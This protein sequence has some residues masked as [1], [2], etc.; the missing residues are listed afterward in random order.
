VG[1]LGFELPNATVKM[2][3]RRFAP[4]S[5]YFELERFNFVELSDDFSLDSVGIV[6][7]RLEVVEAPIPGTERTI[8][9][10]FYDD[11]EDEVVDYSW[12]ATAYERKT[13]YIFSIGVLE[14]IVF[15]IPGLDGV[16]LAVAPTGTEHIGVTFSIDENGAYEISTGINL[17]LRFDKGL[18]K[19]MLRGV[20]DEGKVYFEEETSVDHT[21]IEL[22]G[23]QVSY[24]ADGIHLAAGMSFDVNRPVMIGDSGVILEQLEDVSL[25]F[26][27]DGE[28]P[29]GVPDDWLGVFIGQATARFGANSD[30]GS[31]RLTFDFENCRIGS[32]GFS[33]RAS[34]LFSEEE[35]PQADILGFKVVIE[36]IGLTF[37][38]NRLADSLVRGT[39]GIPFFDDPD[40]PSDPVQFTAQISN[41]GSFKVAL[42]AKDNAENLAEVRIG[43]ALTLGVRKLLVEKSEDDSEAFMLLT[44]R[45]I[46][47]P[48]AEDALALDIE[49]LKIYPDGRVDL[50][51][52]WFDVKEKL[53]YNKSGFLIGI[54]KIGIGLDADEKNWVGFSGSLRLTEDLPSG[55]SVEGLRYSWWKDETGTRQSRFT[56]AG[57]ALDFDVPDLFRFST[58]LGFFERGEPV[59]LD[60]PG[61]DTTYISGLLGEL[62]FQLIPFR[63]SAT[64]S[65]LVARHYVDD[66]EDLTEYYLWLVYLD[67]DLPTGIL[68]ANTGLSIY[69]F[70]GLITQNMRPNKP[71]EAEWYRDW[72]RQDP[73]GATALSKWGSFDGALGVGIGA[74]F[75]TSVD[76]G[77]AFSARVLLAASFPGPILLLA[78][79]ANILEDRSAL[80]DPGADPLFRFLVVFDALES[81]LLFCLEVIYIKENILEIGGIAEVFV[82]FD[83]PGLW[84]IYVGEEPPDR[85][86]R[87]DILEIFEANAYFML[88]NR[89]VAFGFYIGYSLDKRFGPL[90]LKIAAYLEAHALISW[91]P[92]LYAGGLTLYG[93]V[94]LSAF[95]IELGLAVQAMVEAAGPKPWLIAAEFR[96]KLSLPWPL[97][98]P[99][100]TV[101]LRWEE[102]IPPAFPEPI[103]NI[104]FDSHSDLL[105]GTDTFA[106]YHSQAEA[107]ANAP[108]PMDGVLSIIF[109]QIVENEWAT[110][111][112][113]P[114]S[115][116]IIGQDD[117]E[118]QFTYSITDLQLTA[119]GGD[120]PT[121]VACWAPQEFPDEPPAED[122]PQKA[123]LQINTSDVFRVDRMVEMAEWTEWDI[124]RFGAYFCPSP[125]PAPIHCWSPGDDLAGAFI[126]GEYVAEGF[127]VRVDGVASAG[128][129]DYGPD[130]LGTFEALSGLFGTQRGWLS[131][132]NVRIELLFD[133]GVAWVEVIG[134]FRGQL[135]LEIYAGSDLLYRDVLNSVPLRRFEL[136]SDVLIV[137]QHDPI[138]RVVLQG[139]EIHLTSVCYKNH[140]DEVTAE[141]AIRQRRFVR[142]LIE[143]WEADDP[144]FEPH[145]TYQLSFTL[146]GQRRAIGS[147]ADP[148]ERPWEAIYFFRTG[149]PPSDLAAY[150]K[151]SIPGDGE[152]RFFRSYHVEV[153]FIS[154]HVAL[155]YHKVDAPLYLMLTA[156]SGAPLHERD[157]TPI[158]DAA[159]NP[160]RIPYYPATGRT[161]RL[162]ESQQRLVDLAFCGTPPPVEDRP[163]PTLR[164]TPG[165]YLL[166]PET[167]YVGYLGSDAHPDTKLYELS[168]TTSRFEDFRSMI[169]SRID[170]FSHHLSHLTDF[171][172]EPRPPLHL[173]AEDKT[174]ITEIHTQYGWLAE[175]GEDVLQHPLPDRDAEWFAHKELR[176]LLDIGPYLPTLGTEMYELRDETT[177][178]GFLIQFA[179]PVDW[180]RTLLT[181]TLTRTEHES[182]VEVDYTDSNFSLVRSRDG[183]AAFIKFRPATKTVTDSTGL[184]HYLD[185]GRFDRFRDVEQPIIV[186]PRNPLPLREP[187]PEQP[188][189][190][191]EILPIIPSIFL[192]IIGTSSPR[193]ERGLLSTLVS[194]IPA[195]ARL[196][197]AWGALVVERILSP[198]V[199]RAR[200]VE[201]DDLHLRLRLNLNFRYT[202][203]FSRHPT[204]ASAWVA[205]QA[206]HPELPILV[207]QG[208]A[209]PAETAVVIAEFD[210][211]GEMS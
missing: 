44:A 197:A 59:P 97:P 69:G 57:A 210:H 4:L 127:V 31:E 143:Q 83:D 67:V 138:T 120:A 38:S 169:E 185:H 205:F 133:Q 126:T 46:L 80:A 102:P 15:G 35:L 75:G 33:G 132:G 9:E 110:A 6:D 129:L 173:S 186:R 152:V 20:T 23:V 168:F 125:D 49:D 56:L 73:I 58:R 198:A 24:D 107:E 39:L 92:Q 211:L 116:I 134:A 148:D 160:L 207:T 114:S 60:A 7:S 157:G 200:Q 123:I 54:T 174:R 12:T 8:E 177:H 150:V 199:D 65:F 25:Y 182:D 104:Q 151:R 190:D 55:A 101:R 70:A 130:Q 122:K 68:L 189:L 43:D 115:A 145:T 41:E 89:S 113:A 196:V 201:L 106:V 72:Y 171:A 91:S 48:A 137:R 166:D 45:L 29:E 156:A 149:G 21:E 79:K 36:Q 208:D 84:H 170:L 204:V 51:G 124:H 85:R 14:E 108:V 118:Y 96:V 165:E 154:N 172:F 184:T 142:E 63:L 144:L 195:A 112:P 175:A 13:N 181:A 188:A 78:G 94:L 167:R 16:E 62:Q 164:F 71:E 203:D 53:T 103:G 193:E 19:P 99:E 155:M 66:P 42:A 135:A 40:D 50:P 176:E 18:L 136:D 139:D 81:S 95:G 178:F 5:L 105:P 100:A 117:V 17:A 206:E 183:T 28:R 3:S 98:D 90:R 93:E 161:H 27:G 209:R 146:R 47:D 194:I 34:V 187:I 192:G 2:T 30:A 180:G 191:R 141:F 140:A 179:E 86:V 162:R 163:L 37:E 11:Q 10:T 121:L 22:A 88:D 202:K 61:F 64:G 147:G 32:D 153:E 128:W 76:N 111:P 1:D 158:V 87:A 159:G 74:T 119:V 82:D 131:A 52:G 77:H 109:N 26:T